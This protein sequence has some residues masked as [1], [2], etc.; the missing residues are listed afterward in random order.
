MCIKHRSGKVSFFL[1][2][3]GWV[4]R[5]AC[6]SISPSPPQPCLLFFPL[7]ARWGDCS[8][9]LSSQGGNSFT[10]SAKDQLS[11]FSRTKVSSFRL[12]NMSLVLK[13]K[14]LSNKNGLSVWNCSLRPFG[15]NL[16]RGCAGKPGVSGTS[17]WRKRYSL[18]TNV[19]NFKS[20]PF[21]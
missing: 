20:C 18:H 8:G 3:F 10:A 17:F 2:W 1:F 19:L 12:K 7:C 9:L 13:L 6:L 21:Y 14:C 4:I 11:L 15:E 16:N 5:I